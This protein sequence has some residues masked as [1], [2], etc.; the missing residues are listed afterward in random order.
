M[1]QLWILTIEHCNENIGP[2]HEQLKF[3]CTL[4][5]HQIQKYAQYKAKFIYIYALLKKK[6]YDHNN[7]QSK[8]STIDH[9]EIYMHARND[10]KQ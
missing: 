1:R 4:K 3:T 7:A 8:Q 10:A 5:S 6:H 9:W 2:A